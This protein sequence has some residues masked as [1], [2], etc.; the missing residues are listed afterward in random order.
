MKSDTLIKNKNNCTIEGR[1]FVI[2]S[3]KKYS[4]NGTQPKIISNPSEL[5]SEEEFKRL[6]NIVTFNVS[7]SKP[8]LIRS[9]AMFKELIK[10]N[11]KIKM[12]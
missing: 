8:K 1:N 7:I 2:H 9:A 10:E 11:N 12:E 6:T 5:I 4:V 3:R